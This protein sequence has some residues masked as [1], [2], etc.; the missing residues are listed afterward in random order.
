VGRKGNRVTE[1]VLRLGAGEK[2]V[3]DELLAL[4]YD[5]LRAIAG[6]LFVRQP[7]SHTLQPTAVV[8]E[9][10][11]KIARDEQAWEGRSH[12]FAVAARAMRQVLADHARSRLADRRGRG[13]R[14]VT[15]GEQL[16]DPGQQYDVLD[17]NDALERLSEANPRHARVAELRLFAGLAVAEIAPLLG[18]TPRTISL[19][20]R[21]ASAWLRHILEGPRT[22]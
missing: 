15:F 20:W 6:R 5:E 9:A 7:S 17:L 19:D 13:W 21:S 16:G 4:V 1:L 11:L 18:V 14:K 12:F 2:Q 22:T 10:W 3:A 8:N